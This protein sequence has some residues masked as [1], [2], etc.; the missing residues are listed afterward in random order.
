MANLYPTGVSGPRDRYT[1]LALDAQYERSVGE[2]NVTA[3]ARWIHEKEDLAAT[4]AAGGSANS[5]NTLKTFQVDGEYYTAGRVGGALGY[6]STTGSPE[7]YDGAGRS[8]SANNT[9][10]LLSWLVF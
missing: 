4:F 6:F 1:D 7:D 5:S 3:H 10:Y 2:G 8:A 9:L